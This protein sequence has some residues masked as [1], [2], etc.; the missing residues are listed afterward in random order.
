MDSKT[1]TEFGYRGA[2]EILLLNKEIDRLKER[3]KELD[4]ANQI[5]GQI[6]AR[7]SK[8]KNK[9]NR[10]GDKYTES[11]WDREIGWG[12]LPPENKYEKSDNYDIN[13]IKLGRKIDNE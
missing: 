2:E 4:M 10:S 5:R 9:F 7:P 6:L 11:Q 8:S 12:E 1:Y 13:K 3:V